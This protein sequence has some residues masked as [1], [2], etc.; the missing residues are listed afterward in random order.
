[1]ISGYSLPAQPMQAF[2]RRCF[3]FRLP[4]AD[5]H[6]HIWL[7]VGNFKT[8]SECQ[9]FPWQTLQGLSVEQV[10]GYLWGERTDPREDALAFLLGIV[11]LGISGSPVAPRAGR[12]AGSRYLLFFST[13]LTRKE[14][15]A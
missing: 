7:L 8:N 6:H 9:P 10:T 13:S 4:N 11:C 12:Q 14:A 15:V 5:V 1:M 2:N 3:C